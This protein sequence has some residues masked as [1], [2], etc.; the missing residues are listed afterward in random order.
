MNGQDDRVEQALLGALKLAGDTSWGG[1]TLSGIA[2]SIGVSLNDL[3]GL[4]R[5][6]LANAFDGHFDKAMSAEG[7]AGG[8][9]PRERLFDVIM[10]RFEA[11]EDL[12]PGILSLMQHRDRAPRLLV[13]LPQHRAA[14]AYWALVSAGLDDDKGAPLG[15]KLA[16]LGLV[17]G[18]TERAWRKDANGDF[19]LTMAA[20][21]RGLR[22]AEGRLE[23]LSAWLPKQKKSGPDETAETEETDE[24]AG[25][26]HK[27]P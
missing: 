16:G 1:L 21:D 4:T 20:L 7:P 8:E 19:A 27:S 14:S 13:R 25:T 5:D 23:R 24:P 10:L 18:Q 12:R 9:P 11:M 17:I 3:H 22:D 26:G 6:D 15:L 2:A